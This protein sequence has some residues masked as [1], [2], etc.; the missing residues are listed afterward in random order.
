MD[1][2]IVIMFVAIIFIGVLLLVI[3]AATRKT[4]AGIDREV[5]RS[6]WLSIERSLT[7]DV[8][9]NHLA[10]LNA[11]KLL[12]QAL[13]ARRFNGETLGERLKSAQK[14]LS[15]PNA[16]WAA[17]KLRNKI[18]H[19]DVNISLPTTRQALKAFKIAL[20]DLGAL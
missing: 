8:A 7:G 15:N 6:K 16:V 5:F 1:S 18:A 19:E 2:M 3:V 20:K 9:A 13:K 12:D 11:D 10:I 14:Q 17:H 4:P